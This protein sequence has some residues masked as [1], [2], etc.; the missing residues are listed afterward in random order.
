VTDRVYPR[1]R[2]LT[3]ETRGIIQIDSWVRKKAPD[4]RYWLTYFFR[5][6]RIVVDDVRD[7]LPMTDDEKRLT[8][9]LFELTLNTF[10]TDCY[11]YDKLG[12]VREVVTETNKLDPN[13][14]TDIQHLSI[15]NPYLTAG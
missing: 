15:Q 4:G 13:Q 3:D 11:L 2:V 8:K 12:R 10:L 14:S 9:E 7:R 6:H 1:I 5:E